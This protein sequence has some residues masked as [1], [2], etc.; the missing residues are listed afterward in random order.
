MH[1][2]LK[3]AVH[4]VEGVLIQ[5]F[6]VSRFLGHRQPTSWI[7]AIDK[8]DVVEN[9]VQLPRNERTDVCHVMRK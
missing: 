4:F 6:W 3:A 2:S 1:A 7:N 8:Y 5:M 9:K